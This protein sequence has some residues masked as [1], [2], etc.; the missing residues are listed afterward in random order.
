MNQDMTQ[1]NLLEE[2]LRQGQNKEAGG[3]L[4]GGMAHAFNNT[5]SVIIGYSD[6]LQMNL[7]AGDPSHKHAV[8]IAKAARRAAALTYQLLAFGLKQPSQPVILDLNA[9]AGEFEKMLRRVIGEDID[10][11]LKRIPGLGG[12]R[13]DPGQL[14]QVL[15]NLAVSARDGMARGHTLL[16]ETA[17][18]EM[19]ET[20]ARPSPSRPPGPYV[21]LS[22]SETDQ[23]IDKETQLHILEPFSSTRESSKAIELGLSAAC[24]IVKQNAGFILAYSELGKGTTF[25]LYLPR[26]GDGLQL[27]VPLAAPGMP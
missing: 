1:P 4:A 15:M 27:S 23:G 8:E 19:D 24:A 9:A 22:V 16:I 14:E 6:L 21:M 2:Q 7:P 17:N 10:I 3:Q 11:T 18:V 5:L 13:I 26:L 20:C 12:V 25:Q